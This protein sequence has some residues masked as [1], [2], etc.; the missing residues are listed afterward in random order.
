MVPRGE[1][2]PK[3]RLVG[4]RKSFLPV[5]AERGH[6]CVSSCGTLRWSP[7]VMALRHIHQC[8]MFIRECSCNCCQRARGKG[9]LTGQR[10]L[11]CD[12]P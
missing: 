9:S 2:T 8:W 5:V 7:W 1:T 11:K 4:L 12:E 6:G 10:E 3:G